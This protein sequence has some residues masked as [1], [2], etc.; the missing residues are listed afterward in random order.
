VGDN[1]NAAYGIGLSYT[2]MAMQNKELKAYKVLQ[3]PDAT[4][5]QKLLDSLRS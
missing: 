1:S 2:R 4:K 3:N 5:A